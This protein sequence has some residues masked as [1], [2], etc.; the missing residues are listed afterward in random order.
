MNPDSLPV[1]K[2][3]LLRGRQVIASVLSKEYR[4]QVLT[5]DA[6]PFVHKEAQ[7]CAGFNRMLNSK[8]FRYIME[9]EGSE[10]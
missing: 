7:Y 6:V 9:C 2:Q 5:N 1:S 3:T 10:E 4:E 8:N